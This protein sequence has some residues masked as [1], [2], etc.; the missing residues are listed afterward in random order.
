MLNFDKGSVSTFSISFGS[1]TDFRYSIQVKAADGAE[2][3]AIWTC[4]LSPEEVDDLVERSFLDVAPQETVETALRDVRRRA[5]PLGLEL[6]TLGSRL[7]ASLFEGKVLELWQHSL[8]QLEADEDLRVELSFDPQEER[9]LQ[10]FSLPWEL[11][12]D[13]QE[14]L[15]LSR[16][17]LVRRL[18]VFRSA[19]AERLI[20]DPLRVLGVVISSRDLDVAK[21]IGVL[22]TLKKT[23]EGFEVEILQQPPIE[24]L[25]RRLEEGNFHVLHLMGHGGYDDTKEAWGLE[26]GEMFWPAEALAEQICRNASQTRLVVLNACQSGRAMRNGHGAV[27]AGV[28]TALVARGVPAVIAMQAPI[29]DRAAIVLAQGLYRRLAQGE[30]TSAALGSA[31]LDLRAAEARGEAMAGEFATPVLLDRSS[32]YLFQPPGRNVARAWRRGWM[33]LLAITLAAAA[34]LGAEAI[35]LPGLGCLGAR[36]AGNPSLE[37]VEVQLFDAEPDDTTRALKQSL[38]DIVMQQGLDPLFRTNPP[39]SDE[40]PAPCLAW[41]IEID[42]ERQGPSMA[43][44]ALIRH[45]GEQETTLSQPAS[46]DIQRTLGILLQQFE[47]VLAGESYAAVTMLANPASLSFDANQ[48]ATELYYQGKPGEA[49]A[50]LREARLRD[51]DDPILLHNLGRNLE[52]Q[53]IL[54]KQ[55]ASSSTHEPKLDVPTHLK[56]ARRAL[57]KAIEL[58]PKNANHFYQRGSILQEQ[59][60]IELA[61]QDYEHALELRPNFPQAANNLAILKLG[62]GD[63]DEAIELLEHA[64]EITAPADLSTLAAIDKNLGRAYWKAGQLSEAA[65]LL[66][67]ALAQ[68]PAE[69]PVLRAEILELLAQVHGE[70]L[71]PASACVA[72]REYGRVVVSDPSPERRRA[73]FENQIKCSSLGKGRTP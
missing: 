56:D 55:K 22:E 27:D 36:L 6:K 20:A 25:R 72:W 9:A 50:I 39:R 2:Q 54:E 4:P 67:E 62:R 30:S 17:P 34:W 19:P 61:S 12:H 11:L 37:R 52:A 31:R 38:E 35:G 1:G 48:R 8:G 26:L 60:E 68:A 57:T 46:Q 5:A 51:G 58:S 53:V 18:R 66:A 15:V 16:R 40:S 10:L 7:Y 29:S 43:I 59:G 41:L 24:T 32:G 42:I 47:L 63:V 33:A 69:R 23:L 3:D 71:G 65:N 45:F 73:F 64:R 44:G 13:G 49:V 21:E 28:A 70:L 14:F